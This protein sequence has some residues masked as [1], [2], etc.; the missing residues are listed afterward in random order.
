VEIFVTDW[1]PHCNALERSLRANNIRF[2]RQ[3]VDKDSKAR[4]RYEKL[5]GGG[6]P[7]ALVGTT[8]VRGNDLN[9]IMR[10]L[11]R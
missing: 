2:T 7:L 8:V 11:G 3:D 9:G 1:C 6:V 10:A 5:G 4:E